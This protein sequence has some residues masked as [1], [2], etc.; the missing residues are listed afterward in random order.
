MIEQHRFEQYFSELKNQPAFTYWLFLRLLKIVGNSII[1]IPV[2][3]L[4]GIKK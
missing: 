3:R 2:I 4:T 1:F